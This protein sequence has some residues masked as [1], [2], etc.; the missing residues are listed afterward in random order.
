[1]IAIIAVLIA[2]CSRP[3]RPREGG[4]TGSVRQQLQADW[5]RIHNYV[6]ANHTVPPA[7]I[8][9][10]KIETLTT[11]A[12]GS[13]GPLARLLLFLEQTSVYETANFSIDVI[14]GAEGMWSTRQ[15][16]SPGSMDFSADPI[17][18]RAGRPLPRIRD[19]PGVNYFASVGSSLDFDSSRPVEHQRHL[20]LCEDGGAGR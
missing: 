13:F 11:I 14:N 20:L 4:A 17:M 1:M 6:D 12:N 19:G 7:A 2:S 3:C 5:V 10:R 16:S 18:R 8:D 15:P 9:T